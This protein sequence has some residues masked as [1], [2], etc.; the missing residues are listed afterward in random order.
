MTQSSLRELSGKSNYTLQ[1]DSKPGFN[2]Q[3]YH[4]H[5]TSNPVFTKLQPLL[6]FSL[7][8]LLPLVSK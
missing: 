2:K 1:I 6:Y 8:V 4:A 3:D 7:L 5:E